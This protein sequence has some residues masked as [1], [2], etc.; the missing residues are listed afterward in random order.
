MVMKSSAAPAAN[1]GTAAALSLR[2]AR[3][4]EVADGVVSLTLTRPDGGR[5]PDWTPGAHVDLVL[6][7]GFTRQYSLCGDRWDAH[8]YRVAVL[9]EPGGRGGS[10]FVHEHV[11]EG[12]LL[13]LGGPRNNFALAPAREYHFVAGGIGITPLIPM[14]TQAELL[15]VPW[16][17]LYGGR[18]RSSMAFAGEL[19]RA[20]GDRVRLLPEDEC[21]RPDLADWLPGP[22]PGA[23]VYA[24][25]PGGLLDAVR[26]ACDRWPPGQ[27]RTERFVAAAAADSTGG[28]EF[29][30]EL[31]RSGTR[32]TVGRD[33]TLLQALAGAGT[34][35]LSSCRQGLCGTCETTVLDGVPDHRDSI[36]DETDRAAGDCMFVCVSRSH[37][38]RLVLDL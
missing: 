13:G 3:R 11:R 8:S 30:V 31:R 15:G 12:D 33:Q 27:V 2:V 9:R 19:A 16:R 20:H 22:A 35:V 26:G 17:L 7:G 6:P 14:I 28:R 32:L 36:L 29:E 1:S 18:T 38:E 5:L 21:G 10:A 4:A 34:Q 23:K 24:C 25:G 37:S